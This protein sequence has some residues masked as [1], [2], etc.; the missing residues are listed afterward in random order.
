MGQ[1]NIS[2]TPQL[3]QFA[4]ILNSGGSSAPDSAPDESGPKKAR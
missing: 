1:A 4:A 3:Q 2:H